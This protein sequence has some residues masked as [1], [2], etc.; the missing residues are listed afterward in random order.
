MKP[1]KYLNIATTGD[2]ERAVMTTPVIQVI[3]LLVKRGVSS[4]PIVDENDVCQHL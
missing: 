3:H 1:L 4:I 2:I